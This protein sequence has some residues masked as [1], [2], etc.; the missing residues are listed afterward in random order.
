[1]DSLH[2]LHSIA[3]RPGCGLRVRIVEVDSPFIPPCDNYNEWLKMVNA[4]PQ[5]VNDV[6]PTEQE[7][8]RLR[9]REVPKTYSTVM[10]GVMN[11]SC[12]KVPSGKP[13]QRLSLCKS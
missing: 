12:I 7:L 6:A 3:L 5:D 10:I 1:M 13:M 4:H 8:I 11:N 9:D 2:A